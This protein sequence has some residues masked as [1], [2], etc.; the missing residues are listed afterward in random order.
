MKSRFFVFLLAVTMVLC[1]ACA[2]SGERLGFVDGNISAGGDVCGDGDG[3]VY[4]ECESDTRHLYKIKTDGTGK[5]KLAEDRPKYINVLDGWVYY[6]NLYDGYA[7]Y[8]IKTDGT[9]RQKLVDGHCEDLRVTENG[10]YYTLVTQTDRRTYGVYRAELT[11]GDSVRMADGYRLA[12]YYGGTLYYTDGGIV[13][14]DVE[15]GEMTTVYESPVMEFSVDETGLYFYDT[16]GSSFDGQGAYCHMDVD[17]N[18]KVIHKGGNGFVH[19]DNMAY[20]LWYGGEQNDYGCIYGINMTTGE[21]TEVL[22][23]SDRMFDMQGNDA[24]C[25]FREYREGTATVAGDLMTENIISIFVVDGEIYVD[26][27]LA[28]SVKTTGN[29]NCLARVV[30]GVAVILN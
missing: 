7:I 26:A 20:Y 6:V 9:E 18:V 2:E 13:S 14:Q 11:G 5:T 16:S 1:T 27:H 21:T 8:R 3:W 19:Y 12:G 4:Y 17:G 22:A 25:S 10:M 15:T 29:W 30:D 28:D 23:L 24:G